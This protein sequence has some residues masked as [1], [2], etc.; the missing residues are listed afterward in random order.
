[1]KWTIPSVARMG[2]SVG[3][4]TALIAMTCPRDSTTAAGDPFHYSVPAH[5]TPP[6]AQSTTGPVP[7]ADVSVRGVLAFAEGATTVTI[8]GVPAYQWHHG[9]GPTAAGMVVGYWDGHG[10]DVLVSGDAHTQTTAVNE[11]IASEGAASNYTDY[12]EPID[13]YPD[14][15]PDLSEPPPGDEHADECVADY[16]NTSQSYHNNRYGWSW[17]SAVGPA[18]EDFPL[19][20]LGSGGH[21]AVTENLYML[22]S[23]SLNWDRFRTEIDAGRPM[24]LLV[25]TGGD[26][27]TDHFVTAVGYAMVDDMQYYACLNTWDSGVHWFEFAPM[28]EGQAWGIYGGVTFRIE[29]F[30]NLEFL[31]LATRGV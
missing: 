24:V 12:C 7:P 15:F 16:M 19:R 31:P 22:W 29:T 8:S 11:M 23:G 5:D 30:D 21:Y 20:A 18:L 13:Y 28:G 17:F 9:C 25:D 26:G 27:S 3:L 4:A 1:M 2:L 14:L 10:F 6:D